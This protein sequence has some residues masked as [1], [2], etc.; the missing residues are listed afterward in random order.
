MRIK[1]FNGK[2]IF[3]STFI[4]VSLFGSTMNNQFDEE[5]FEKKWDKIQELNKTKD[6]ID[7]IMKIDNTINL[8]QRNYDLEIQQSKKFDVEVTSTEVNN[9]I[10][11]LNIKIKN[12]K[13]KM[14]LD[15][16]IYSRDGYKINNITYKKISISDLEKVSAKLSLLKSEI[17]ET[18]GNLA[19]IKNLQ[20]VDKNIFN[21]QKMQQLIVSLGNK[22][23]NSSTYDNVLHNSNTLD[24]SV[25][26]K[27]IYVKKGD[28]FYGLVVLDVLEDGVRVG[29]I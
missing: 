9:I 5:A 6:I 18:T 20:D 27:Q 10:M 14:E 11:D 29:M 15:N 28:F 8:E 23:T 17:R 1:Y 3:F 7:P 2:I 4:T 19:S 25:A 21:N 22:V 16:F 24:N 13:M 26:E 12:A